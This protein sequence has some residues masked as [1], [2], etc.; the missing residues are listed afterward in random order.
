MNHSILRE[1]KNCINETINNI[2]KEI[3]LRSRKLMFKDVIYCLSLMIGNNKSYDIIN[4]SM[5]IDNIINVSSEA[6]IKYQNKI[7]KTYF[8]KL[9]D[10]LLTF[11]YKN[12]KNRI[13]AVDGTYITL[14]KSLTEDGFKLSKN[15]NYSTALVS[16]LF[17]IDREIPINYLLSVDDSERVS[18]KKQ[19]K[20]LKRGDIIIM[21]RGY[22]SKQLLYQLNNLYVKVIFRLKKNMTQIK[23]LKNND[24]TYLIEYLDSKINFRIIKYIINK[25]NYYIGTT[26]YDKNIDY[27]QN[28][29]WSRWKIEINFRHSKYNLSMNNINFKSKK[30]I[31]QNICVHNFVFIINSYLQYYSQLSINPNFKINTASHLNIVINNILYLLI[32]KKATKNI[33]DK[34]LNML[35]ILKN[36]TTYIKK[37]RDYDR[38][39]KKPSSKWCQYGNKYKMVKK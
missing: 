3:S 31:I 9:N 36:T 21:D 29:Y 4:A 15:K 16:T 13:I 12:I 38:I 23:K 2:N 32:Y 8:Y 34:I 39:K 1:F 10:N 7:N 20:Y 18:L 27:L 24:T 17:D 28:L 30:S 25:K 5:K 26:I 14:S 11:I 33:I 6:L 35:D 37:D 22:Y 19:F